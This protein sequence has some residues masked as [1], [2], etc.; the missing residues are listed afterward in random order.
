[1]RGGLK[2][3]KKAIQKASSF[4]KLFLRT[5]GTQE[6]KYAEFIK[7]VGGE[8][9]A[10]ARKRTLKQSR[11]DELNDKLAKLKSKAEKLGELQGQSFDLWA[12]RE[13]TL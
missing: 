1:M 11:I 10:L 12:K 6:K 5:L 4:E 13:A 2:K 7:G 8:K 3:Y 9:Q